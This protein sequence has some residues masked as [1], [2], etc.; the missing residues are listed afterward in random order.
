MG[1]AGTSP[2]TT[3]T[4]GW[5]AHLLGYGRKYRGSRIVE[6]FLAT[7]IRSYLLVYPFAPLHLGVK[8]AMAQFGPFW[9]ALNRPAQQ[10]FQNPLTKSLV[11]DIAPAEPAARARG[12]RGA[13]EALLAIFADLGR[14]NATPPRGLELDMAA[15]L[16]GVG[17][18]P[19][20]LA[21]F[22]LT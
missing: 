7:A 11:W 3:F 20:G 9:R 15:F 8:G 19:R 14:G 5:L 6:T 12:R 21:R 4:G 1:A 16:V 18:R 2:I 10:V 17:A 13:R 22:S